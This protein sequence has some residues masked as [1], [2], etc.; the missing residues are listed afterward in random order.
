MAAIFPRE[1]SMLDRNINIW[2]GSTHVRDQDSNNH[3]FE[4]DK[5]NTKEHRPVTRFCE[6]RAFAIII[7]P[8]NPI[9]VSSFDKMPDRFTHSLRQLFAIRTTSSSRNGKHAK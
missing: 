8:R 4:V 9:H 5:P 1:I 3:I 6:L 7:F 2:A